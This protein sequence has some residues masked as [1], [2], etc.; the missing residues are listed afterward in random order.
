MRTSRKVA[1][2]MG[3]KVIP[4]ADKV[5]TLFGTSLIGYWPMD[6]ASG[7]T[8]VD[9]SGNNRNGAYVGMTLANTTGPFSGSAPYSDGATGINNVYSAGLAGAINGAAGSLMLWAKIEAA[10]WTDATGRYLAS[11]RVDAQNYFQVRRGTENNQINFEY[12][13]GNIVEFGAAVTS[14]TNWIHLAMTWD[15]A[16]GADGQVI[17]YLNATQSGLTDT[18]VGVWVGSVAAAQCLFGGLNITPTQA[19]KGWLSHALLLN[20]AATP[21]EITKIYT[22]VF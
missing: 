17:Y 12:R 18:G 11:F 3:G 22:G 2:V 21:A 13:A 6:E 20:R 10:T 16:A 19:H 14:A 8:A 15:R 7:A 4:Y 1:V 5:K 9:A